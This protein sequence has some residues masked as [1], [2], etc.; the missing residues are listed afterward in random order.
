M[1]RLVQVLLIVI[2]L[3]FI[4]LALMWRNAINSDVKVNRIQMQDTDSLQED[5]HD[6]DNELLGDPGVVS[7]TSGTQH[8]PASQ[9]VN[10]QYVSLGS[11]CSLSQQKTGAIN[12]L[13]KPGVSSLICNES[14]SQ[15]CVGNMY[16]N[17]DLG[18][19]LSTLHGYCNTINDCTQDADVCINNKCI[20]KSDVLFRPCLKDSDCVVES[21]PDD[22]NFL[23]NNYLKCDPLYRLCKYDAGPLNVGCVNNED[24]VFSTTNNQMYCQKNYSQTHENYNVEVYQKDSTYSLLPYI[25]GF[26]IDTNESNN[27]VDVNFYSNLNLSTNYNL[28][29]KTNDGKT[30]MSN[31]HIKE[32]VKVKTRVTDQNFYYSFINDKTKLKDINQYVNYYVYFLRLLLKIHTLNI[33]TDSTLIQN[34]S[35]VF[36]NP[37]ET[38]PTIT[39]QIKDKTYSSTFNS[40]QNMI[41]LRNNCLNI[42]WKTNYYYFTLFRSM[43]KIMQD[44][45]DAIQSDATLFAS[46]ITKE[47][48]NSIKFD[49]SLFSMMFK[50]NELKELPDSI[51]IRNK[52]TNFLSGDTFTFNGSVLSANNTLRV[53]RLEDARVNILNYRGQYASIDDTTAG[54]LKIEWKTKAESSTFQFMSGYDSSTADINTST[55]Y[56]MTTYVHQGSRWLFNSSGTGQFEKF[57]YNELQQTVN[58]QTLANQPLKNLVIPG[59]VSASYRRNQK[60]LLRAG[61]NGT[62][63]IT[64]VKENTT[65]TIDQ[66]YYDSST[67]NTLVI[68]RD[69]FGTYT[70]ALTDLKVTT[71]TD[72]SAIDVSTIT[73]PANYELD[74]VL[75][76]QS[77]LNFERALF[78][79]TSLPQTKDSAYFMVN[80]SST[81]LYGAQIKMF[82]TD[83]D[84]FMDQENETTY[85]TTDDKT[86]VVYQNN[87]M[88]NIEP[89]DITVNLTTNPFN[90][91]VLVKLHYVIY[92]T[93]VLKNSDKIGPFVSATG[94]SKTG[95][96]PTVTWFQVTSTDAVLFNSTTI[97]GYH[98]D[99]RFYP[100][101][102]T[103]IQIDA[104][105]NQIVAGDSSGNRVQPFFDYSV[106][107]FTITK[108]PPNQIGPF[109]TATNTTEALDEVT[110]TN[111]L[112]LSQVA[113]RDYAD[114]HYFPPDATVLSVSTTTG[115]VTFSKPARKVFTNVADFSIYKTQSTIGTKG[116]VMIEMSRSDTIISIAKTRKILVASAKTNQ[117][118]FNTPTG[119]LIKTY[120]LVLPS[121]F[122]VSIIPKNKYVKFYNQFKE[123]L[124]SYIFNKPQTPMV[125]NG[126][127]M[128]MTLELL[129]DR[130][131]ELNYLQTSNDLGDSLAK[132]FRGSSSTILELTGWYK[133]VFPEFTFVQFY[134]PSI[135]DD[136]TLHLIYKS[137]N[138]AAPSSIT[139]SSPSTN[140]LDWIETNV[141]FGSQLIDASNRHPYFR[142][143]MGDAYSN[144]YAYMTQEKQNDLKQFIEII[145]VNLYYSFLNLNATGMATPVQPSETNAL[146]L[147]VD[148]SKA[149]GATLFTIQDTTG[150]FTTI[151]PIDD[152][153][154]KLTA[155]TPE[156]SA[157]VNK[158]IKFL[159]VGLNGNDV[160]YRILPT[161]PLTV[162]KVE[163]VDGSVV[164]TL[165]Q[166]I[167]TITNNNWTGV[168]KYTLKTTDMLGNLVIME[169]KFDITFNH[170]GDSTPVEVSKRID[171]TSTFSTRDETSLKIDL[172]ITFDPL[173]AGSRYKNFLANPGTTNTDFA[174][175]PYTFIIHTVQQFITDIIIPNIV[176][177]YDQGTGLE[178]L[179]YTNGATVYPSFPGPD[180]LTINSKSAAE[181]YV[182][183]KNESRPLA[184][185]PYFPA[186]YSLTNNQI[187]ITNLGDGYI[188]STDVEFTDGFVD[189]A[190]LYQPRYS[191]ND[192]A[193]SVSYSMLKDLDMSSKFE[194][195]T[196]FI[197]N[198]KIGYEDTGGNDL[199]MCMSK[200]P[201]GANITTTNFAN[202]DITC[203]NRNAQAL[204]GSTN[205][206]CQ[207]IQASAGV[208]TLCVKDLNNL[209]QESCYMTNHVEFVDPAN[210]KSLVKIP[211]TNT[212]DPFNQTNLDYIRETFDTRSDENGKDV[213]VQCL[214]Y[215]ILKTP[216]DNLNNIDRSK[217]GICSYPVLQENEICL[218]PTTYNCKS[219]LICAADGNFSPFC[220]PIFDIYHPGHGYQCNH[221]LGKDTITDVCYGSSFCTK[222]SD[223]LKKNCAT[224][225][226]FINQMN[227]KSGT[228]FDQ[229][230][231][232]YTLTQTDLD[233][234]VCG[235]RLIKRLTCQMDTENTKSEGVCLLYFESLYGG[236][237]AYTRLTDAEKTTSYNNMAD[238]HISDV[239]IASDS[240]VYTVTVKET[241]GTSTHLSVI[242][243]SGVDYQNDVWFDSVN[244]RVNTGPSF[245][246]YGKSH[247]ITPKLTLNDEKFVLQWNDTETN[248][249]GTSYSQ[250]YNP[251]SDFNGDTK[252]QFKNIL[253]F[254]NANFTADVYNFDLKRY[255][256]LKMPTVD[257][258]FTG[259]TTDLFYYPFETY[260]EA[261]TNKANLVQI[262]SDIKIKSSPPEI[263]LIEAEPILS[264]KISYDNDGVCVPAQTTSP[265]TIEQYLV[266][267][268]VKANGNFYLINNL[269]V[270]IDD[271]TITYDNFITMTYIDDNDDNKLK[272]VTTVDN[273]YYL[274]QTKI[275]VFCNK[276]DIDLI[277][278]NGHNEIVVGTGVQHKAGLYTNVQHGLG[279]VFTIQKILDHRI[280]TV[281]P[282]NEVLIV[283]THNVIYTLGGNISPFYADK[284][285][286]FTNFRDA[287]STVKWNWQLKSD[288]FYFYVGNVYKLYNASKYMHHDR[289]VNG[290]SSNKENYWSYSD[291][292]TYTVSTEYGTA[293]DMSATNYRRVKGDSQGDTFEDWQNYT[294][295]Y[296]GTSFKKY[297]FFVG[298]AWQMNRFTSTDDTL[299]LIND[300]KHITFDT[301]IKNTII[302]Q[303]IEGDI[304]SS[305]QTN[306]SSDMNSSKGLGSG[307]TPQTIGGGVK[308]LDMA[309]LVDISTMLEVSNSGFKTV[310]ST[311]NGTSLIY[312]ENPFKD[313]GKYDS[314]YQNFLEAV[315]NK[316]VNEHSYHPVDDNVGIFIGNFGDANGAGVCVRLNETENLKLH[317]TNYYA[318]TLMNFTLSAWN[319]KWTYRSTANYNA[320]FY[321]LSNTYLFDYVDG[322]EIN[323][324]VDNYTQGVKGDAKIGFN[325]TQ[326]HSIITDISMVDNTL[327][328]GLGNT[329][330]ADGTYLGTFND[331]ATKFIKPVNYGN[332]IVEPGNTKN[333]IEFSTKVH[334][335][336]KGHHKRRWDIRDGY[337]GY[338]ITSP[339][340]IVTNGVHNQVYTGVVRK[341]FM[342]LWNLFLDENY[343]GDETTYPFGINLDDTGIDSTSFDAYLNQIYYKYEDMT[344]EPI[345]TFVDGGFTNQH[346]VYNSSQ[347]L[348]KHDFY[349]FSDL[350]FSAGTINSSLNLQLNHSYMINSI[351]QSGVN[352]LSDNINWPTWI[353]QLK[354]IMFGKLNV[355]KKLCYI[356]TTKNL[357]NH[358]NYFVVVN[359]YDLSIFSK[360]VVIVD[361][362]DNNIISLG[363]VYIEDSNDLSNLDFQIEEQGTKFTNG[364]TITLTGTTH[365]VTYTVSANSEEQIINLTTPTASGYPIILNQSYTIKST[366]GG[367][368]AKIN[369]FM[370]N[371]S[372]L[373]EDGTFMTKLIKVSSS[374]TSMITG[375]KLIDLIELDDLLFN[376]DI[377]KHFII[378][379]RYD[380]GDSVTLE[381]DTFITEDS[382]NNLYS[383]LNK[384]LYIF[385]PK[386]LGYIFTHKNGQNFTNNKPIVVPTYKDSRIANNG[387]FVWMISNKC[388]N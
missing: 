282:Y 313:V 34:F 14:A 274:E 166:Q 143:S 243:T 236:S 305:F 277:L 237:F 33:D 160:N 123:G 189:T 318:T 23:V 356:P 297:N 293:L 266:D 291:L 353:Q 290:L 308:P 165:N 222:D 348:F 136:D 89:D 151:F 224:T 347:F 325:N 83:D 98:V 319:Q 42:G 134:K 45:Y 298:K 88:L 333:I 202:K 66:V 242:K 316:K 365:S 41:G 113:V 208:G 6:S 220:Q 138:T 271:F 192:I 78:K 52:N 38:S 18:R 118:V 350:F 201:V 36:I 80:I 103:I 230:T 158:N 91:D 327:V 283:Q 281:E 120:Q 1:L 198:L 180:T 268:R 141:A 156:L 215:E 64:T 150:P 287:R 317:A 29:F 223:C 226:F 309:Q 336:T 239:V 50:N 187:T 373:S 82:T 199:S 328:R 306:T 5:E 178:N 8:V 378:T 368:D 190:T 352:T 358:L 337:N 344:T 321:I 371:L 27:S 216:S 218:D 330:S 273:N 92:H 132:G 204:V 61:K 57:T 75:N 372:N 320:K 194:Y 148:R 114:P 85:S 39:L 102:T 340:T 221:Q 270:G 349:C 360:D 126:T 31:F 238:Y 44:N 117:L 369:L 55:I 37:T 24:C 106:T 99:P 174:L 296:V 300:V 357:L 152:T 121:E 200:L 159:E 339:P 129:Y 295:E 32:I 112:M 35:Y 210:S 379:K 119:P 10:V 115:V 380:V 133:N 377:N 235:S 364:S 354:D 25:D 9:K 264:T 130:P 265:S 361:N 362:T 186:E 60:L 12:I 257:V 207:D 177:N 53:S 54:Q 332:H 261:I 108:D 315:Q 280:S 51:A 47:A 191:N 225:E 107:D 144:F 182:L 139:F 227:I 331:R 135:N 232:G 195:G 286:S 116:A 20:K 383:T 168:A 173:K 28:F 229:Q 140:Y 288:L 345:K 155:L 259:K 275:L 3:T 355:I 385:K 43:L 346:K 4:A 137:N 233:L 219:D 249:V 258:E 46:T 63:D 343:Q 246:L 338:P 109:T 154:R 67:N 13:N 244:A 253:I 326:N 128:Y 231:L 351:V 87:Q 341:N 93:D 22:S 76:F 72:L 111:P 324:N 65:A 276:Q 301:E 217:L 255:N 375:E 181:G 359:S 185:I 335:G 374:A 171:I 11:I 278:S 90:N 162:T 279:R 284:N 122:D 176:F 48:F 193:A 342:Y 322:L 19:C 74:V 209:N 267:T 314:Y 2:L 170:S 272:F 84:F 240:S 312:E 269:G 30:H 153:K 254:E 376:S 211:G 96:N 142:E 69:S 304:S 125:L 370:K 250:L 97:I 213:K 15:I 163:V 100:T 292:D 164:I 311:S 110:I 251:G 262:N 285:P 127:P 387:Q 310:Y 206:I 256:F 384:Q 252:I 263:S 62:T 363:D 94:S 367:L 56:L 81:Q 386:T 234:G 212:L 299:P 175:L 179:Y 228:Q 86:P 149:V 188:V 172:G 247:F 245:I 21:N 388:N 241:N 381:L 382:L 26:L 205:R 167:T 161:E 68:L 95:S 169:D 124:Y 79:L 289:E 147:S 73:N 59:K 184:E 16:D 7:T 329:I 294:L 17:T 183:A 303:Q 49:T 77:V 131:S 196:S 323:E 70:G 203:M 71:E 214:D 105:A 101:G 248:N 157:L 260:D 146:R 40:I 334:T 302:N 145:L 307:Y 197:A 104:N 366:S 58:N